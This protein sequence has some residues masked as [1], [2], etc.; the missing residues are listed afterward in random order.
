MTSRK[1]YIVKRRGIPLNVVSS[2]KRLKVQHVK[3]KPRIMEANDDQNEHLADAGLGDMEFE[4]ESYSYQSSYTKRKQKA[5]ER[6]ECI[7]NI[8]LDTVIAS[9]GAPEIDCVACKDST[10]IV[11]CFH[12]GPLSH[13]CENCAFEVHQ[14][15]LFHH[16]M[17]IL[18]VSYM[19]HDYFMLI[20]ILHTGRSF[21]A[22]EITKCCDFRSKSSL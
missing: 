15:M 16:Y 8:A 2:S 12:C 21:Q 9:M 14:N 5:A 3:A 13:Y 22:T 6:W 1:A 10:G 19:L 20:T 4:E 7:Q 11:K 18:D 17:E